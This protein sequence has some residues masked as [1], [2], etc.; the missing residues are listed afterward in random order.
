M[1]L[2]FIHSTRDRTA[3]PRSPEDRALLRALVRITTFWF[4]LTTMLIAMATIQA[5]LADAASPPVSITAPAHNAG[6]TATTTN[7]AYSVNGSSTIPVDTTCTVNGSGSSSGATNSVPL[8]IGAN[9]VNVSC[10]NSSGTGSAA[11]TI[12]RGAPPAVAIT[13]PADN[14]NAPSGAVNVVYT[15]NS[16]ST[17]PAG[18]TCTVNGTPST[19]PGTNTVNLVTGPNAITVACSNAYGTDTRTINVNGAG[20]PPDTVIDTFAQPSVGLPATG[21]AFLSLNV[22]FHALGAATSAE[23]RIPAVSATWA[24]CTSFGTWSIP[25]TGL[26]SGTTYRYEIR[27]LNGAAPDADP[28]SGYFYYDNAVWSVA[29][30]LIAQPNAITP[31][32]QETQ[33]GRHPD[34]RAAFTVVGWEDPALL[35]VKFPDGMMTNF[36]AIP[37]GNRCALADAQSSSCP[38]ASRIGSLSATVTNARDGDVT[39]TGDMY[40]V[41]AQDIPDQYPAGV[42]IDI[43]LPNGLGKIRQVGYLAFSTASQNAPPA[44]T[45]DGAREQVLRLPMASAGTASISESRDSA[46]RFH[47]KNLA[48]TFEG[49]IGSTGTPATN[50]PLITNPHYCG[51]TFASTTSWNRPD[52]KQIAVSAVG[53]AGTAQARIAS[54]YSVTC[55]TQSFAPDL[56]FQIKEAGDTAWT[57]SKPAGSSIMVRAAITLPDEAIGV[58][59]A[60]IGRFNLQIPPSIWL[61]AQSIGA[62]SAQCQARSAYPSTNPPGF[63][64]FVPGND[65]NVLANYC[66]ASS[67]IGSVRLTSP[68]FSQ[69][70]VGRLYDIATTV[71]QFGIWFDPSVASTNP[72]GVEFGILGRDL[73]QVTA[74]QGDGNIQTVQLNFNSMPD[75][76]ITSLDV[77]FGGNPNRGGS[78]SQEPFQ[79]VTP[80][81]PACVPSPPD[82][83]WGLPAFTQPSWDAIARL[84]PWSKITASADMSTDLFAGAPASPLNAKDSESREP[85][86]ITGCQPHT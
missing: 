38:A 75:I 48:A 20:L 27:A 52:Q 37:Q 11:I 61:N 54:P 86:Y 45:L 43:T 78:L 77:I 29:P 71:P 79:M 30:S 1:S 19:T 36:E 17:I 46:L 50:R 4:V 40:L 2:E 12:T 44:N 10:S 59:N 55:T 66:P 58:P 9:A 83:E 64:T 57:N 24:P 35:N 51:T 69:A 26:T 15:V 7:I 82:L 76:P 33:T 67:I 3:C 22:N 41:R 60:T 6:T 72:R 25:T 73:W 13:S 74:D 80:D 65:P 70:L 84:R 68:L 28:A 34:V 47:L 18:V 42:A 14:Y 63:G 16:S 62:T 49:A 53:Y 21:A 23:C 56:T 81:D 85:I 5:G 32:G 31:S 39:G 8:V